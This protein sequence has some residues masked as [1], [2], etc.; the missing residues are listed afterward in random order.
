MDTSSDITVIGAGPAGL[1]IAR[2]LSEAGAD[3]IVFERHTD[4]GG[5][6]DIDAPH[7]PMYESAHFITSRSVS[8]FVGFPMPSDYPDY[9]S[10]QQLLSYIRSFAD[11]FNLRSHIHFN[12]I[13][14]TAVLDENQRWKIQLSD[15]TTH[16]SRYLVCANGVNWIPHQ[17]QW[18]GHFNGEIRHSS[19]YRS[20]Q[21]FQGK[22]VLIVGGGNSGADIACDASCVAQQAYWSVRRGYHFIPKYIFG[23][24][25]DELVQGGPRIPLWL[26]RLIL[27]SLL[28]LMY[29][30]LQ[31]YGL[32]R[33]DHKLFESHPLMNTQILHYLGQG[34]CQAKPDIDQL[35]GDEVMFT[36]GSREQVDLI[37]TATGYHHEFPFLDNDLLGSQ[38]DGF[39]LYLGLFS[40]QQHNL[41]V[42]GFVEFASAAYSNFDEMSR[43]IVADALAE[44]DS[45]VANTFRELKISHRPNLQGK[46]RYV[47]SRRH[48]NYVD[49]D[50]Y[51]KT[52]K[53]IGHKVEAYEN[54]SFAP[55]VI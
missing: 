47:I 39:N 26:G 11:H 33:P 29:G 50:L 30:D 32:P 6:W 51:L 19:T 24:P 44:P 14:K 3:F 34:D 7:S 55:S 48:S 8:G 13:V 31:R 10:H 41:A 5:I 42:L 16:Y 54:D 12:T 28:W 53:Q 40:R 45:A 22:R 35:D 1:T 2:R 18:S 25:L 43:L 52:L 23:T 15:G 37:V 46:Q 20:I 17:V 36:D 9:P 49:V 21:E 4:V 27:G 38:S